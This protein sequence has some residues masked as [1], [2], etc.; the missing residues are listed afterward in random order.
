MHDT[1]LVD[2]VY[3]RQWSSLNNLVATLRGLDCMG[4]LYGGFPR[5]RY[6][7]AGIPR[8]IIRTF[9]AAS[10]WNYGARRIGL[11]AG[12]L[13]DEP[14]WVGNWVA[15]HSDLAPIVI[16]NG[17][18]HRYLFPKL[19]GTGR[20]LI[21]ERGSMHPVDF[22]HFPERARREA[23]YSYQENLPISLLDEIEKNKLSDYII[24]GSE[25]IR[26][27]YVSRGFP[28]ERAFTCRYG[29]DIQRFAFIQRAEPTNRPIRVAAVGMIGFRK[30]LHRLLRLGEWAKRRNIPL[31]IHFAGPVQDPEAHEMLA[32]SSASTRLHGVIKGV[33]MI[34][35]LKQSDF[36]AIL[37]Y[38]EGL[39]FALLE[40]MATGL[41]AL[42]STDT[43]AR[44]V[45][46]DGLEGVHLTDF[47]DE[48]FDIKLAELLH[49]PEQILQMGARARAKIESGFTLERYSADLRSILK[50]ISRRN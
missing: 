13:L 43:G 24:A 6:E 40:G 44:E 7:K 46:E 35:F 49:A 29:I 3:E 21:L 37:S 15:R 39:P 18:A 2:L 23:G 10:L 11:P 5:F 16:A 17:T 50:T 25:M 47:T 31:E 27:S 42:V 36:C 20:I 38:E 28:A 30:G 45:P 32:R 19:K 9:P 14:R 12:L 41:P 33:E 4:R 48:E 22:F 26:Q 1:A 8:E 34:E